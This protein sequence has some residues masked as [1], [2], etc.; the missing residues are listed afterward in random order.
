[1]LSE[2]DFFVESGTISLSLFKKSLSCGSGGGDGGG[3]DDGNNNNNNNN[4][5]YHCSQRALPQQFTNK[6]IYI[7][8]CV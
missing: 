3:S 7:L 1:M 6:N 2:V 8:I 5:L 4:K